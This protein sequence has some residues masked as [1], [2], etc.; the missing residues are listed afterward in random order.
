MCWAWKRRGVW[1]LTV[2]LKLEQLQRQR[3]LAAIR[4]KL[5]QDQSALLHQI[6]LKYASKRSADKRAADKRDREREKD[7]KVTGEVSH[8]KP[9]TDKQG[10]TIERP[11]RPM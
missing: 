1:T 8:K 5:D 4:V 7:G 11:T 10:R 3:H 9:V 2:D 6:D